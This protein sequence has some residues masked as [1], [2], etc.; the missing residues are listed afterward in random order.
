MAELVELARSDDIVVLDTILQRRKKINPRLILGKGKLAE[1]GTTLY[2]ILTN[3]V[4]FEVNSTNCHDV[5][6]YILIAD[7]HGITLK[8]A[9]TQADL[10][11]ME[12]YVNANT[13]IWANGKDTLW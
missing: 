5:C 4:G 12:N 3:F 1:I 10:T 6:S 7:Y 9:Y 13:I 11:M 2:P 8:F